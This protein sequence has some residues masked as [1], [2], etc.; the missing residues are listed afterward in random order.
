MEG[1]LITR[2]YLLE[3]FAGSVGAGNDY[4]H[5]ERRMWA[6]EPLIKGRANCAE[7]SSFTECAYGIPANVPILYP[8]LGLYVDIQKT[9][10]VVQL[11]RPLY[12]PAD[13]E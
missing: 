10:E 12:W 5:G 2:S 8:E 3:A 13:D 7:N 1:H 9:K 4:L 6:A 11:T